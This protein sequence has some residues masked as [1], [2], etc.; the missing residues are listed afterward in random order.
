MKFCLKQCTVCFETWPVKSL[1]VSEHFV[2]SRCARDKK[3]PKKFSKENGMI[4]LAIPTELQGLTH[5]EEMLIAR[6]LPMMHVYVR[7]G[8]QRGYSGHFITLPQKVDQ[9]ASK[10]P[11]YP[12]NLAVIVVQMKGKNYSTRYLKV[13]R[14]VVNDALM[15]LLT[16]NP[17]YQ[18]LEVDRETLNS[19]PENAI[20]LGLKTV[21]IEDDN[22]S[23]MN[24]YQDDT[25]VLREAWSEDQVYSETTEMSSFL[26]LGEQQQQEIEDMNCVSNSPYNGQLKRGQTR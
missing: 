11:H 7:H 14:R 2:C 24:E 22:D 3:L 16:H 13:R 19:L 18:D 10:L 4:P 9:L 15:W 6:A 26:P 25:S 20:P 12:K 5:I 8:G 23:L 21:D 17:L 1:L